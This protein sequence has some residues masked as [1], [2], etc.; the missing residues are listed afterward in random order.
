MSSEPSFSKEEVEE[1][2]NIFPMFPE[3]LQFTKMLT[4]AE[5]A[6]GKRVSLDEAFTLL[7][8]QTVNP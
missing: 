6:T 5:Q 2:T 7:T 8:G 1:L 4:E 3:I